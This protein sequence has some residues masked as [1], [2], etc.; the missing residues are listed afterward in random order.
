MKSILL[1][2]TVLAAVGAQAHSQ[3]EAYPSNSRNVTLTLKSDGTQQRSRTMRFRFID[4]APMKK[5]CADV[6]LKLKTQFTQLSKKYG[7]VEASEDPIPNNCFEYNENIKQRELVSETHQVTVTAGVP[8]MIFFP[9]FIH[10][11]L[12]D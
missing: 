9:E 5:S 6:E 12:V 7:V 3:V 1:A 4:Y 8:V 10:F 2:L 11:E